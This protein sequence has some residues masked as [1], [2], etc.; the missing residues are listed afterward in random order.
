MYIPPFMYMM[1]VGE[2][3]DSTP[4]I[5]M[6]PFHAPTAVKNVDIKCDLYSY[7][8]KSYMSGMREKLLNPAP[9][10]FMY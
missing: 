7:D 8:R 9:L 4:W 10:F 5:K 1:A 2:R 6:K 3:K